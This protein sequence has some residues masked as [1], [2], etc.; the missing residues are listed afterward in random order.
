MAKSVDPDDLYCLHSI[1]FGRLY[2][3]YMY[4]I[5]TLASH[6][7]NK[8]KKKTIKK[9]SHTFLLFICTP[10]ALLQFVIIIIFITKYH[11]PY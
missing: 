1:C 3:F 4:Q 8:K 11:E 10:K 6:V 9:N 7:V 2:R 5:F